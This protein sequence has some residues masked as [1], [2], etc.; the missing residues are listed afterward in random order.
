MTNFIIPWCLNN[1]FLVILISLAILGVGY[2]SLTHT[3]I[4]AIPDIGDK[5]VIVMADWPN[6]FDNSQRSK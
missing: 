6:D 2:Y 5:Q 3:T 1:R 4:D